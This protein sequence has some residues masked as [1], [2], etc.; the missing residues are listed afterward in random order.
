M[1]GPPRYAVEKAWDLSSGQETKGHVLPVV[2]VR[3]TIHTRY[4]TVSA[5]A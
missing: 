1:V 3:T 4:T 5:T 2:A